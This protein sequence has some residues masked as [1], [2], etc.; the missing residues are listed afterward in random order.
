TGKQLIAQAIHSHSPR[1]DEPFIEINCAAIP[2]S[3]LESEFFGHERGAFTGAV[4]QRKGRFEEAKG[5]TLFL[6][7]IGEISYDLQAKLLRV[8]QDGGYSR[9][10]GS[11]ILRSNAR[12]IAATNRDLRTAAQEGTFRSDLFYR[13]HVIS[14]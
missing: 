14:V 10:G 7:E 8:L 3:L 13:L 6:D 12:V 11:A 2:E 1:K 5:G 9:V 4:G